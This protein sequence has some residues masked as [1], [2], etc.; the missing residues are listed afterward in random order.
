MQASFLVCSVLVDETVKYA[1]LIRNVVYNHNMLLAHRSL[2]YVVAVLAR[3]LSGH[4]YVMLYWQLYGS[5]VCYCPENVIIHKIK[6]F[7]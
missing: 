1:G 5:N 6:N 3:T 2:W 4:K 7:H